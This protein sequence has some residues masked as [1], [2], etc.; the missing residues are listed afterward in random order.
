MAFTMPDDC[1]RHLLTVVLLVFTLPWR[2]YGDNS[3]PTAH[4]I[5]PFQ[6]E[7]DWQ[8][9]NADFLKSYA[10]EKRRVL[11]QLPPVL[12]CGNGKLTLIDGTLR[13][14][15]PVQNDLHDRLKTIDHEVLELYLI[16]RAKC[17]STLDPETL[18]RLQR[19][20]QTFIRTRATVGKLNLPGEAEPIEHALL[21]RSISFVDRVLKVR[22]VSEAELQGFTRSIASDGLKNADLAM[23]AY[24]DDLQSAV[25]RLIIP[26]TQSK[27]DRL[28]ALILGTHM[29]RK[30]NGEMQ[31]FKKLL[32][33]KDEGIRIVYCE[34]CRNERDALDLLATHILD[35]S[36]GSE[37]FG[38][39]LRMHRDLRS[40]AAQHYLE[41]HDFKPINQR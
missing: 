35:A 40:D 19:L 23:K 13:K 37:F 14:E 28:H 33:E 25:D 1:S 36:I 31:F 34:V 2:V 9:A 21:D 27:R 30:E 7:S 39:P 4:Q 22:S 17:G 20:K 16:L 32:G 15:L 3:H 10:D 41:K 18:S 38:D 24:F 11:S 26:L 12:I 29:S 6:S 8:A 5:L